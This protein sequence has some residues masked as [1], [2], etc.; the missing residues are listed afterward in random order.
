MCPLSAM[1]LPAGTTLYIGPPANPLP[2]ETQAKIAH[3]VSGIDGIAEAHLPQC[4]S[5]GLVDPSAQVLVLVLQQGARAE[6]VMPQVQENLR[7]ALSDEEFLDI[8]PLG[9][10][11]PMIPTIRM[12]NTKLV[13]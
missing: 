12:T 8:F 4:Y 1:K 5:K 3:A 10:G 7:T 9:P 11:H 2:R 6:N 13:I